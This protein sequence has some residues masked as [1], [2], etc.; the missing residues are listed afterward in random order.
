MKLE[1]EMASSHNQILL[2]DQSAL[3]FVFFIFLPVCALRF[4]ASFHPYLLSPMRAMKG[5]KESFLM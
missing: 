3:P 5:C 2:L 4:P 1:C